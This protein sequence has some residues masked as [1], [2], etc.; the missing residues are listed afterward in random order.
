MTVRFQGVL[1]AI[2]RVRGVRGAMMVATDDGLV[3]A[4]TLMEGVNG[5]AVAALAASLFQR[6]RQATTSAAIGQPGF[7]HLQATEGGLLALDPGGDVL[8]VAV[9]EPDVNVGLVRLE[10]LRASEVVR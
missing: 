7:V 1:D 6:L 5:K 9:T 3:V 4:D 2:T 8:L 10:M